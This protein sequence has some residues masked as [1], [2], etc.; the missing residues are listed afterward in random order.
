MGSTS[1]LATEV[2][3]G[4]IHERLATVE[5]LL[6]P[7][8]VICLHD[9]TF[10]LYAKLEF[11]NPFG[12]LKDR[13]AF[14]MLKAAAQRGDI[15]EETTIFESS[16]GNLACALAGF[17]RLLGLPFIPVV[18]PNISSLYDAFLSRNVERVERVTER[19]D[20]G[21]FLKTRL[22]KVASLCETVANSYWTSQY[23][24][25]DSMDTHYRTTGSEISEQIEHLDYAFIGVGS[26]GTIA[27][28]SRRLKERFPHITI[29]AVDVIGSVIFGGTPASRYIPGIGS[30]IQPG[31][32]RHAVIDEVI[33]VS[34]LDSVGGCYELYRRHGLFVGGSSGAVYAAASR[35]TPPATNRR[36]AALFLC[37]DRGLPYVDTIF[38]PAWV[39]RVFGV[40]RPVA[41]VS[42]RWS[43][44]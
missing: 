13:P 37:A 23:E 39:R 14:G 12:S 7:T 5:R 9:E 11:H 43:R 40:E 32:L 25:K 8:P 38:N 3:W 34:E 15:D 31:L 42:T 10:D 19:D 36:P 2:G 4:T 24:N 28:V 26:G 30:S 17:C 44:R 1:L 29:V 27:G 18:D 41:D 35:Y 16:S 6:K 21:G 20:T 33:S 22:R